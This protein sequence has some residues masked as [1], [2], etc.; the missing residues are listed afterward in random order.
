MAHGEWHPALPCTATP[1]PPRRRLP[2]PRLAG[3]AVWFWRHPD[4]EVLAADGVLIRWR[5]ASSHWDK[6]QVEQVRYRLQWTGG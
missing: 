3:T 6:Q 2:F 1:P 5:H 4:Q